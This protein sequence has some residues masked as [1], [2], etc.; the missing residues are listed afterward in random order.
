MPCI[1]RLKRELCFAAARTDMSERGLSR[2]AETGGPEVGLRP[3][4]PKHVSV[5]ATF[6]LLI[7]GGGY[8]DSGL[9]IS[10]RARGFGPGDRHHSWKQ[11]SVSERRS[12]GRSGTAESSSR[13]TRMPGTP[14]AYPP[15]TRRP[16]IRWH[17]RPTSGGFPAPAFYGPCFTGPVLRALFC[18]SRFSFRGSEPVNPASHRPR[19]PHPNHRTSFTATATTSAAP[20]DLQD[21]G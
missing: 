5:V 17:F 19:V 11:A 6:R 20:H 21:H 2:G 18:A 10:I 3:T 9:G 7:L 4:L 8:G 16:H 12:Q 13:K 1:I 15:R 14:S